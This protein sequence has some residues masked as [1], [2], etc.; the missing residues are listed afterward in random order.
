MRKTLLY[1]VLLVVVATTVFAGS[2]LRKDVVN[3]TGRF[4]VYGSEPHTYLGFIDENNNVYRLNSDLDSKY[5]ERQGTLCTIEATVERMGKDM[6]I[7]EIS[8][9]VER[10]Y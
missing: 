6:L 2:V 1:V 4:E 7:F 8:S 5:R 9:I 10:I 3:I